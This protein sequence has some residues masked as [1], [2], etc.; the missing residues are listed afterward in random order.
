MPAGR[1][2][3]AGG[4]AEA[5]VVEH[6]QR[7][8]LLRSRLEPDDRLVLAVEAP[9]V[10]DDSRLVPGEDAALGPALVEREPNVP[11]H[12]RVDLRLREPT[13]EPCGVG[14]RRPELCRSEVVEALE[15]D[16]AALLVVPQGTDVGGLGHEC[17]FRAR[18]SS[19]SSASSRCAQKER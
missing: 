9:L 6:E 16:S 17:S 2:A 11:A 13:P 5:A 14:D 19:S 15:A 1:V 8:E 18:R 3:H 4:A 10:L 7:S 12:A